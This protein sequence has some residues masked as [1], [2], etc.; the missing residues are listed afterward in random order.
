LH[1]VGAQLNQHQGYF[2]LGRAFGDVKLQLFDRDSQEIASH[3]IALRR[4][5]TLQIIGPTDPFDVTIEA[6]QSVLNAIES[7]TIGERAKGAKVTLRQASQLPVDWFCYEGIDAVILVVAGVPW[8]ESV[9]Q[10]QWSALEKWVGNG[11]QLVLS[12]DPNNLQILSADGPLKRLVPAEINGIK[13]LRS[14]RNL[15]AYAGSSALLSANSASLPIVNLEQTRGVVS[16]EQDGQPI[17]VRAPLGF[18]EVVMVA[19]NLDSPSI[20]QWN[21]FKSL[22]YRLQHRMN[23][24]EAAQSQRVISRGGSVTHPGFDDLVGQLRVPLDQFSKVRFL[25]F[26]GI[27]LLIGLYILCIGPGDY[28][29]LRRFTGKMELTWIS[30]PLITLIFCGLAI[31]IAQRTRAETIQLNQ[32][33]LIDIDA[34]T[35]WVR[36]TVWSSLYSPQAGTCDIA[37]NHSNR[38]NLEIESD[39]VGWQGLPGKGYGGMQSP[40]STNI[41]RKPYRHTRES[42]TKNHSEGCSRL[43][44]LP[45]NVSSTKALLTQYRGRLTTRIQ[46][47]L[48]LR[49][50]NARLEGTL[51][52]PFEF[53]LKN[54]RLLFENH[55]YELS[56][57]LEVG[58]AIAVE[59]E[60]KERTLVG[61]LTRRTTVSVEGT[62]STNTQNQPWDIGETRISRIA[63][64]L[65]FYTA[66]GGSNY[67]AGLT[68]NYQNYVDMSEQLN[69]GRAILVGEVDGLGTVLAIDGQSAEPHY[70]QA[71]TIVR[72]V[73]PVSY[74]EKKR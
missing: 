56:N 36:G 27:A 55:A 32:L 37:L 74:L 33:E 71:V 19:L 9:S 65:M 52:N 60:M 30:F 53:R 39:L 49:F 64:M 21:G 2:K 66:A 6:G 44:E 59:S 20:T 25:S 13:S 47:N 48:R 1:A 11:G 38:F 54:C 26:N 16:V 14:S 18:G 29:L 3:S 46:S 45:L 4:E 17:V 69:L 35:G 42:V 57:P 50:R 63:D 7:T 28:F 34:E 70:D 67:T 41:T 68:H 8:L 62:K 51:V 73:L 12:L 24:Q 23:L 22:V 43:E 15:D 58:E 72:I 61:Y 40:S 31:W 5:R 10:S